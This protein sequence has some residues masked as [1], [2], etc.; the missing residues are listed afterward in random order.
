M[1]QESQDQI[2]GWELPSISGFALTSFILGA[3][4][5]LECALIVSS[6]PSHPRH[7]YRDLGYYLG[8][9]GSDSSAI[10]IGLAVFGLV[11]GLIAQMQTRRSPVRPR[12]CFLAPTGVVMGLCLIIMTVILPVL[13]LRGQPP[14]WSYCLNNL[15]Q[16]GTAINMYESDWDDRYPLVSG[17]GREF[18]RVYGWTYNYRTKSF[19]GERRWFQNVIGP[20]AKNKKIFMRRPVGEDGTWD[21]PGKGEVRY[22][23]NRHGGFPYQSK[24]GYCDPH[25]IGAPAGTAVVK[26][27]VGSSTAGLPLDCDPPTSYWFN[28]YV[29]KPGKPDKVISGRSEEICYKA[30][31]APIVWDTPCGFD[32]GHGRSQFAHG[33][34]IN[35][36]YADGHAKPF[37]I[38]KPRAKEWLTGDFRLNYGSQGW[39]PEE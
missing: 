22:L 2:E 12:G 4:G 15:K 21:I 3:I 37:Q 11:F 10:M 16:I 29:T 5:L 23:Y 6:M 13:E 19:H 20:Y 14:I 30:A 18:E 35:V 36:C 32:D 25:G 17:P 7:G 27:P 28:V 39:F 34:R 9:G 8:F 1:N 38:P 24:T 31:D 33:D 26:A